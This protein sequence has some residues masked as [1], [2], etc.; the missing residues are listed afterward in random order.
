[1][2]FTVIMFTTEIL[3]ALAFIKN[4][5]SGWLITGSSVQISVLL[6]TIIAMQIYSIHGS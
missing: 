2:V 3:M 4:T 6:K 1:M 5:G